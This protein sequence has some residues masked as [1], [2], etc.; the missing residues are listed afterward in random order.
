MVAL[1]LFRTRFQEK[2]RSRPSST[3]QSS[4]P[5]SKKAHLGVLMEAW[6]GQQWKGGDKSNTEPLNFRPKG[7]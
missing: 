6:E 2:W 7:N 1:Q 4:L 5:K 3:S